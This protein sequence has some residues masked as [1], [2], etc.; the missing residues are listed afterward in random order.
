MLAHI[1]RDLG[2]VSS[3]ADPD[4]WLKSETKP[5]RTEYHAYVLVYVDDV[6]HLHHDPETFM[7][8]LA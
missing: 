1:L 4:I 3:K 5:D 6:I 2:Y 7:N 8:R